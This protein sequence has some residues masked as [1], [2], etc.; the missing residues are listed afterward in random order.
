MIGAVRGSITIVEGGGI[1]YYWLSL[2]STDLE[3]FI[4]DIKN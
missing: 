1:I 2:I 4:L 3:P